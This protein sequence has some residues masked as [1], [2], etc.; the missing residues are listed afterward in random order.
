[1]ARSFIDDNTAYE[2]WL[3]AQCDVVRKDLKH[4][5]KRKRKKKNS[6]V[7]LRATF[8]RW[9]KRIEKLCADLADAPA[10]LSVGDTHI[11][12]FGTWR[13]A[14]GRWVWGVNDFDEAATIPY[15]SDLVRLATSVRLSPKAAV[16]NRAATDAILDGYRA[17]LADPRPMLLDQQA[18]PRYARTRRAPTRT[19][20]G[21]GTRST[22]TPT[23]PRPWRSSVI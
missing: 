7:F 11:E 23:Q 2:T 20:R 12:N 15:P 14:E 9:A 4:K 16:S 8:F 18:T 6:F 13:D 10:V 5:H 17:G 22:A 3:H 19:A 1:M 21:S